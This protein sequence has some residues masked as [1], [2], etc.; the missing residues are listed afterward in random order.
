MRIAREVALYN[1]SGIENGIESAEDRASKIAT[2]FITR[3]S[4]SE[5][6]KVHNADDL[7]DY[8]QINS[9][10]VDLVNDN[11]SIANFGE[12]ARVGKNGSSRFMINADSLQAYDD[13]NAK[14]FEV[15]PNGMTY[16][17]HTVA[18]TSYADGKA[19]AAQSAAISAAASD[20]T[21]KANAAQSA[22]EATA[23]A[24]A[25]SK[26]NAAQSAAAADATAKANNAKL[27]ADNYISED[28]TGIKVH[29]ANDS[30]NYTHIGSGGMDVRVS[31]DSVAEFGSTARVGKDDDGHVLV[32]N[33][34]L[35]LRLKNLSNVLAEYVYI[36]K[37]TS[38]FNPH[39]TFGFRDSG[40]K[41]NY[42]FVANFLNVAKGAASSAFGWGTKA[43]ATAQMAVGM[44]NAEDTS[45]MFIVG[46]G[47]DDTRRA[48]GLKVDGSGNLHIKGNVYTN[49]NADSS[50]GKL[51]KVLKVTKNS[52]SSLST[53]IS[54]SAITSNMEVLHT[55]LSNPSAQTGD[56]T[57]TTS[58]GSLSISG[59]IS[60]TTNIT[61]YL[62]E[63]ST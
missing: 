49:C 61:L 52:V 24:D 59:S 4:E 7:T 26:A 18:D 8:I 13:T 34:G 31:G 15:S 12:S 3:V 56:W 1:Q 63:P 29:S 6:I 9:N 11:V 37:G 22:A 55:V 46:V 39:F 25:T 50:G 2:S 17:S 47:E 51:L 23:S 44:W 36:G 14:Y 5:G 38:G 32:R 48:N 28:S 10:G 35:S 19:S 27:Y 53:T 42:S 33:D 43:S 41:G 54:N 45:S 21:S 20:A 62:A 30:S 60:G 57:V 16:G 40:D 58:N